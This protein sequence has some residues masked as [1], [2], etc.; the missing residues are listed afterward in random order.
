ME[1]NCIAHLAFDFLASC[2]SSGTAAEIGRI[3]RVPCIGFFD[4]DEIPV[5]CFNSA[6]FRILLNVPG[7]K[8]SLGLPGTVTSPGLVG[9]LY[10]LWLPR[11]RSKYHPSS[12]S[13]FKA[14]RTF[15]IASPIYMLM[16]MP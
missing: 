4:D 13:I 3:G 9:C 6:C 1:G 15:I 11:V 10:C 16:A 8:S 14:L 5:H 2:A 12:W 7:P